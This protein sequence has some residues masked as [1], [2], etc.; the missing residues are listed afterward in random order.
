MEENSQFDFFF[1]PQSFPDFVLQPFDETH[2]HKPMT[3]QA[4]YTFSCSLK[5]CRHGVLSQRPLPATGAIGGSCKLLV[6]MAPL[7]S[8]TPWP[9]VTPLPAR[10]I[11]F[12]SKSDFFSR[13]DRKRKKKL[14]K[15]PLYLATYSL[16]AVS[17]V[18]KSS[19]SV[20]HQ[21]WERLR[22]QR[23]SEC[24]FAHFEGWVT[25]SQSECGAPVCWRPHWI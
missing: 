6:H 13:E 24:F 18:H 10:L 17:S 5:V 9:W 1:F 8:L 14:G 2:P 3:R 15:L 7:C 20:T 16:T 19:F 12:K 25:V 11:H 4:T 21:K 23:V 22:D